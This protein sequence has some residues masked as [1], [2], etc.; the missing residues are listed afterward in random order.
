M[1]QEQQFLEL[2]ANIGKHQEQ[3]TD[4]TSSAVVPEARLPDHTPQTSHPNLVG[5]R[6]DMIQAIRL[7]SFYIS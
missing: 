3:V 5:V 4:S 7:F 2:E 1:V 6:S